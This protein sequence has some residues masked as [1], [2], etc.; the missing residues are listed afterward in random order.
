[1]DRQEILNQL[2]TFPYDWKEIIELVRR[3]LAAVIIHVR[4]IRQ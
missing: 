3:R 1:M 4:R 2:R